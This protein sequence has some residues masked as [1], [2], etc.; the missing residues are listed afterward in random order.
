M[1]LAPAAAVNLPDER[2]LGEIYLEAWRLYA[3]QG[4]RPVMPRIHERPAASMA[5][6][7]CG[8]PCS[9]RAFQRTDAIYLSAELDWSRPWPRSIITHELVHYFQWRRAGV[10]AD[11][12]A[13]NA[14]EVEA[15]IVQS[16]AL[17]A[18]SFIAKPE[19]MTCPK[20]REP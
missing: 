20:S 19:L 7:F 2:E 9:I 14:R 16:L 1:C 17:D 5:Q 6:E 4:M 12:V 11:C 8:K 3:G 18:Y 10:A 15:W 13:A